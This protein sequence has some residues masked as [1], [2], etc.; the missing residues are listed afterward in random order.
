MNK[1]PSIADVQRFW[2][3]NPLFIGE[4]QNCEF[5]RDY[6][7]EHEAVIINDGFVGNIYNY[8][9]RWDLKGKKVLDV[10]CGTG[11]W[12]RQFCKRGMETY[13]VDISSKAVEITKKSLDLFGYKAVVVTG[14]AEALPFDDESFDHIN[15]QGVI[16]HTPDTQKCIQEFK[17]VLKPGGSVCY[18]VYYKNIVL[19]QRW[20]FK[21]V[22]L[23]SGIVDVGLKGRGRENLI[24]SSASPED[25]VRRYDG[26]NNPIGKSFTKREIVAMS[27]QSF[28]IDE[29][30][31][32]Y[33]PARA[34]PIRI[35]QAIH[36]Y[37]ST[38]FGLMIV[39]CGTKR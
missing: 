17:R 11:F 13:G 28:D 14:N 18:S 16:H 10:G 38:H 7:I 19:R 24:K 29:V 21:M 4:A 12:V 15:C 3:S 25:L 30:Y 8:F 1:S 36:K 23:L 6:F 22:Q 33:F 20:L 27:S 26:S 9:F 35:P 34:I 37:L 32:W 31:R 5:T 39:I 2:D